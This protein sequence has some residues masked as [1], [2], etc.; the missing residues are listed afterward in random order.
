MKSVTDQTQLYYLDDIP[1]I[2]SFMSSDVT[3]E[4]NL[5]DYFLGTRLQYSINNDTDVNYTLQTKG[6]ISIV[7]NEDYDHADWLATFEDT[8]YKY[9]KLLIV[10]QKLIVQHCVFWSEV[11]IDC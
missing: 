4:Y 11:R 6:D 1:S 2:N 8:Y 7:S 5:N 3:L 10:D 9:Y